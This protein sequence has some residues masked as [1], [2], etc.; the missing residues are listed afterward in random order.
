MGLGGG[1]GGRSG[2]QAKVGGPEGLDG[3]QFLFG[4]GASVG[5][6]LEGVVGL[7]HWLLVSR[8]VE[9]IV[10]LCRWHFPLGV[11]RCLACFLAFFKFYLK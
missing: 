5:V 3:A 6:G 2:G 7:R 8:R 10:E 4:E 1:A 11:N 9:T